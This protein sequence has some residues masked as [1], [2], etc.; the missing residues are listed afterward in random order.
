MK[1]L[2]TLPPAHLLMW[3]ILALVI[4]VLLLVY[5]KA[6]TSAL[7]EMFSE[8]NPD[9]SVGKLSSKRVGIMLFALSIIYV[10]IYST[11]EGKTIDLPAFAMMIVA[12]IIGWR[13]AT[14]DQ[15]SSLMDKAKQFL[16]PGKTDTNE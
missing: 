6:F 11:Q 3:G 8:K 9:G 7:R 14:P 16:K 10:F 1:Q 12:V 5:F 15:I 13:I 4:A 2:P